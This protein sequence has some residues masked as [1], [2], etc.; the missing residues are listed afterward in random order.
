[1]IK[2][3][4]SI[5]ITRYR[6]IT[7]VCILQEALILTSVSNWPVIHSMPLIYEPSYP[8]LRYLLSTY[9]RTYV[10][11]LLKLDI[12]F[13]FH[14]FIMRYRNWINFSF[15]ILFIFFLPFLIMIDFKQSWRDN[16]ENKIINIKYIM[17]N[18]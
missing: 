5:P 16:I 12:D 3:D 9:V 17:N 2:L 14:R 10:H 4:S 13:R 11:S 8:P 6:T 1:M 7:R 15:P 18:K